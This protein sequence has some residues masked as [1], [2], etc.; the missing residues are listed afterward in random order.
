V[1]GL[2]DEHDI[3]KLE[4]YD[5]HLTR[6]RERLLAQ[7]RDLQQARLNAG[8]EAEVLDLQATMVD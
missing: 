4:R 5:V 3:Q 8:A 2:P 1:Y 6:Q 7:L